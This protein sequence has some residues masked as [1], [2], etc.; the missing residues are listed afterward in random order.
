MA[1]GNAKLITNMSDGDFPLL[2]DEQYLM[3]L[4]GCEKKENRDFPDCGD[5][6]ESW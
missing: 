2:C 1:R 5:R 4:T 6:K 3:N